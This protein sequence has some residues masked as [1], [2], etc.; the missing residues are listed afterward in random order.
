MKHYRLDFTKRDLQN[1]LKEEV[2]FLR[3]NEEYSG[4]RV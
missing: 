4:R 1:W 3:N 2:E